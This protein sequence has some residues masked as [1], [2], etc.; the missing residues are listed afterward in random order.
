MEKSNL[1]MYLN[2]RYYSLNP[3]NSWKNNINSKIKSIPGL[4]PHPNA[5]YRDYIYAWEDINNPGNLV[6]KFKVI[7]SPKYKEDLY[8]IPSDVDHRRVR[9]VKDMKSGKFIFE[10][11][12]ASTKL[13]Y[14][15]RNNRDFRWDTNIHLLSDFCSRNKLVF[16]KDIDGGI[17]LTYSV[18]RPK[19]DSNGECYC[20][21]VLDRCTYH[22]VGEERYDAKNN[23]STLGD[24]PVLQG[25]RRSISMREKRSSHRGGGLFCNGWKIKLR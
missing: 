23:K 11:D 20:E 25:L 8:L 21:V 17:R 3:N 15:N 14:Y 12:D 18:S 9:V 24:N 2:D 7:E 6:S 5:G 19:I 4:I 1:H 16:S 22:M 13:W 10:D